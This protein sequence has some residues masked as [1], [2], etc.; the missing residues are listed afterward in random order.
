[1]K[2]TTLSFEEVL[3]KENIKKSMEKK[4]VLFGHMRRAVIRKTEKRQIRNFTFI[5]PHLNLYGCKIK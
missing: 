2:L 5:N 4:K 1:M 3:F